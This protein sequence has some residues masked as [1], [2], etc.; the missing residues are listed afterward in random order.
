[1]SLVVLTLLF[2][3]CREHLR[4]FGVIVSLCVVKQVVSAGFSVLVS[5]LQW[6]L[7]VRTD[8]L[9]CFLSKR[10]GALCEKVVVIQ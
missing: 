8:G 1:M 5:H 7:L 3:L 10:R 6:V 9:V 2:S 4:V